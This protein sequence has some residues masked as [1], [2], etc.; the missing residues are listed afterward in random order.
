MPDNDID[1][2]NAGGDQDYRQDIQGHIVSGMIADLI[3]DCE[4]HRRQH[5]MAQDPYP[6]F[7][8]HEIGKNREY[9]QMTVTKS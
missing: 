6:A 7:G 3:G 1:V 2:T 5:E 9:V 8:E 4:R